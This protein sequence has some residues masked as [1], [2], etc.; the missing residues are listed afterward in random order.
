[1]AIQAMKKSCKPGTTGNIDREHLGNGNY[2]VWPM[3]DKYFL[4]TKIPQFWGL[5]VLLYKR[6]KEMIFGEYPDFEVLI[7]E[8]KELENKINLPI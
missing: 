2:L 8:L 3:C 5:F 6:L 1:M 4:E 7:G